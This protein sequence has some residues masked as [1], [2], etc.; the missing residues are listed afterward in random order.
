MTKPVFD[1]NISLLLHCHEDHDHEDHD[2]DHE[3]H[4]HQISED[5]PAH[6][7]LNQTRKGQ[8]SFHGFR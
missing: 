3:D 6:L 2:H 7:S 4:C 1:Q 5:E 8:S